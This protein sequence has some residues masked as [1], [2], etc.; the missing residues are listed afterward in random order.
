MGEAL[1][2]G[3]VSSGWAEVGELHVVEPDGD[4]IVLTFSGGAARYKVRIV[5]LD[6]ETGAP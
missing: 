6:L 1:V 4:R 2:G 5:N 3:L